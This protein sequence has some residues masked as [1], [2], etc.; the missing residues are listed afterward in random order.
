M[1]IDQNLSDFSDLAF[2]SAIAVY[3]VALVVSLLYYGSVHLLSENRRARAARLSG[4]DAQ[5]HTTDKVA[6]G[7]AGAESVDATATP[8]EVDESSL[9]ENLRADTIIKKSARADKVGGVAQAL[10]WLGVAFHG[11]HFV[12]RGV[13]N[14]RFPW[15]NL[16]EYIMTITFVTMVIAVILVS[17]KSVR[18]VWP[19][20]LTPVLALM[21]YGGTQLYAESG[22]LVP[23][24]NS[25]W[26]TIHVSTVSIGG[27]IG[28][29]SGVFSIMYLLR[30]S[31]FGRRLSAL[32][33]AAKLD[34]LAY[35]SAVWALPIFGLGIIFGAIWA[36]G[37]WG[38]F[39]GWDPKETVSFVTWILYA[40][41]LHARA[42]PG[43]RNFAQWINAIAFASMVFNLFFINLVVSGL[44]SYA[45]LQ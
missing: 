24:L 9:P 17:R 2:R 29:I 19:W 5:A 43:W 26:F 11:V 30:S 1:F 39:W 22:P 14:N 36:D 15:G 8:F 13:A 41:F 31:P 23:A 3:L 38:R 21:F 37:A 25:Y 35:R 33:A 45:G 44:H 28:L 4:L 16:F 27:S 7:A 42:T 18:V 20:I 12:T 34:A 40:A 10:V 6:V 32:P